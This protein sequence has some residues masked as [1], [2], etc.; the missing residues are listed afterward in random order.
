MVSLA[1]TLDRIA[2]QNG[3]PTGDYFFDRLPVNPPGRRD[4][5]ADIVSEWEREDD[6][7]AKKRLRWYYCQA[8]SDLGERSAW[9]ALCFAA[10]VGG[11][12]NGAAVEPFQG[13]VSART[14]DV[15]RLDAAEKYGKM[16]AELAQLTHRHQAVLEMRY[17][18]R[19]PNPQIRGLLD[20]HGHKHLEP[21]VTYLHRTGQVEFR[22]DGKGPEVM[23]VIASAEDLLSAALAAYEV[24]ARLVMRPREQRPQ[25]E[26]G[27]R[28]PVGRFGGS[29]RRLM[30]EREVS[31]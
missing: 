10:M 23:A 27:V 16:R 24:V 12:Q 31:A 4:E 28:V 11:G 3:T 17:S 25:G 29:K 7:H 18:L 14:P 5:A 22:M 15:W 2:T 19:K 30:V 9:E 20:A 13:G 8:S 21:V 26:R 1:R 6:T